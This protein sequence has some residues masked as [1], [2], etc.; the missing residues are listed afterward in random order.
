VKKKRK[1]TR[2]TVLANTTKI[3]SN[4]KAIDV[5]DDDDD[6]QSPKATTDP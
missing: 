4:V 1:R 2:S 3:S 5:E 6:V